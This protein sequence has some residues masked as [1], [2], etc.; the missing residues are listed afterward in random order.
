MSTLVGL[1]LAVATLV[2]TAAAPQATRVRSDQ[3]ILIELE[4][5][6]NAAVYS[7]DAD[8]VE[9]ILADEFVATYENGSV[10]DKAKE[11]DLIRAFN[12]QVESAVQEDFD[13]RVYGDAAVVWFTLRLVGIRQDQRT[14][15]VLRFTDVFVWR[16][17]RWQ[18][19]SSQS[20]KVAPG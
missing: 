5:K 15:V 6:W 17:N 13:V 10:G 9:T 11:L 1:V 20:T 2:P 8:F 19:V 16:D 14:E 3:E 12:Q 18:C 7:R 4:R